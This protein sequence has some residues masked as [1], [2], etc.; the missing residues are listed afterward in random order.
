[1][2]KLPSNENS[3][4]ERSGVTLTGYV[5][6]VKLGGTEGESCNCNAKGKD[7]VDAHI[8]VIND[9]SQQKP[10]NRGMIVV[11]V[12][13]R[14]RRLAAQGLLTTNIGNDWSTD[15]LKKQL[16]GHWVSF[17]GWLFFDPDHE[18]ESWS[19]DRANNVGSENWRGSPWEIHPVMGI[20]VLTSQPGK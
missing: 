2:L 18:E 12:T 8:E 16:V 13:E 11:E 17:S 3:N 5:Q 10:D 19:N 7:Q 15:Q 4:L 1:M 14:S 9:P 20:E 6:D